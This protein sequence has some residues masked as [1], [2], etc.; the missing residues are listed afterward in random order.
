MIFA[1][2]DTNVIV[3]AAL[4]KCSESSTPYLIFDEF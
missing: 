1:V 4:A 3:S 2:I